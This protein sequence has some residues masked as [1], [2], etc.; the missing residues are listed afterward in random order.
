MAFTM[1]RF[2]RSGLA[3]AQRYLKLEESTSLE[4]ESLRIAAVSNRAPT[5]SGLLS[6]TVAG[7]IRLERIIPC[8]IGTLAECWFSHSPT[9]P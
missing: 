8:G 6:K 3:H 7:M 9:F 5:L 1:F 2:E 4:D